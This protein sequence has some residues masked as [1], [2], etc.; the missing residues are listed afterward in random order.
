MQRPS[1]LIPPTLGIL[2]CSVKGSKFLQLPVLFQSSSAHHW[3]MYLHHGYSVNSENITFLTYN[4][5]QIHR[6][7]FAGAVLPHIHIQFRVSVPTSLL[8]TRVQTFCFYTSMAC[9]H[10]EKTHRW[11]NTS[12]KTSNVFFYFIFQRQHDKTPKPLWQSVLQEE[13]LILKL[14]PFLVHK[15]L[16]QY[17][18]AQHGY[19]Q[20]D[21]FWLSLPTYASLWFCE[22]TDS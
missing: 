20:L 5:Y 22:T 18:L 16:Q 14:W 12:Q 1:L 17:Q 11:F 7:D 21:A 3:I 8:V 15:E 9:F 19:V 2:P 10:T 4:I 13:A 6:L